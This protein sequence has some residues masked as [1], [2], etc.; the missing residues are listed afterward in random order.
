MKEAVSVFKENRGNKNEVG[1][2]KKKE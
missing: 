1:L 2:I